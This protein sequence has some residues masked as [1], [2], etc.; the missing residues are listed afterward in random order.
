MFLST[1]KKVHYE[2]GT[3][4][5]KSSHGHR[6]SESRDSGV[7]SSSASD[8]A[9]LGT[10]P[11]IDAPFSNLDIEDQRSRP[12]AVH[13]ALD[14]AY[15][16]IRQLEAA[17]IQL[18]D[19]LTDSNKENRALKRERIELLNKVDFLMDDLEN[20]TKNTKSKR[21]TSPRTGGTAPKPTERRTTPPRKEPKE[22]DSRR[23][24]EERLKESRRERRES[25][26]EMPVPLYDES[27]PTAPQPP[28]NTAPTPFMPNP[29]RPPSISVPYTASA[30]YAPPPTVT[31]AP[32]MNYTT[33]PA[34]PPRSPSDHYPK[35]D[36]LYHHY[37]LR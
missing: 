1:K 26:R 11:G 9:S 20:A 7:G 13:E 31:Y 27:P 33:A 22:A 29:S 37:P 14:A 24:K 6:S 3:K 35:E 36:G 18:N 16:K 25:W 19:Q 17:N 23:H 8:R 34:Y 10:S 4:G 32:P 30:F 2:P 12:R 21:E 15:E 28:P 5:G